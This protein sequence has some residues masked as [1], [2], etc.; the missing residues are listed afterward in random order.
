[1]EIYV[2]VYIVHI[3]HMYIVIVFMFWETVGEQTT[4]LIQWIVIH[5][6]T[7]RL[8]QKPQNDKLGLALTNPPLK[9]SLLM[10]SKQN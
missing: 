9:L 10:V 8:F 1:M 5:P 3:V 4:L 7:R 6:G 2:Y